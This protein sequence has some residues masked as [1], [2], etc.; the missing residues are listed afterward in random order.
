MA[1]RTWRRQTRNK[2]VRSSAVADGLT[3]GRRKGSGGEGKKEADWPPLA[4]CVLQNMRAFPGCILLTRVGGF[5]EVCVA[6]CC[7]RR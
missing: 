6:E 7:W 2:K 1:L 4:L 5:Y 3:V